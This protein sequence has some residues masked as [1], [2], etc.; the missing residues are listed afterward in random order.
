[1]FGISLDFWLLILDFDLVCLLD[2]TVA[3]FDILPVTATILCVA[4][5]RWNYDSVSG[6]LITH[7]I[8]CNA[9]N[10]PCLNIACLI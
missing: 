8:T 10:C 7:L 6:H 1:M 5:V 2:W 3:F 4:T 9:L